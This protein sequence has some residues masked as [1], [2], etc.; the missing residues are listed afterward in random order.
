MHNIKGKQLTKCNKYL[1]ISIY[2]MTKTRRASVES[3][4]S[5]GKE[6]D[7]S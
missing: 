5:K 4:Q 1:F 7:H 6:L 3:R 2:N